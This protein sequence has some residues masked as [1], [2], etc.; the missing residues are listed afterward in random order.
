M[1]MGN[2]GN[3]GASHQ[4][5]SCSAFRWNSAFLYFF[6][7]NKIPCSSPSPFYPGTLPCSSFSVLAPPPL[8][9]PRGSFIQ[10]QTPEINECKR[11]SQQILVG[12]TARVDDLKTITAFGGGDTA[13]GWVFFTFHVFPKSF[14]TFFTQTSQL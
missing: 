12:V 13:W 3:A 7:L 9:K 4:R 10:H 1:G 2:S 8:P 14:K 6:F 11:L 5:H